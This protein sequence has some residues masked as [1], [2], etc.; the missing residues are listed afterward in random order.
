MTNSIPK[1]QHTVSE[2]LIKSEHTFQIHIVIIMYNTYLTTHI[3]HLYFLK[4]LGD[5][6]HDNF[7]NLTNY[8]RVLF[9]LL[10]SLN[11]DPYKREDKQ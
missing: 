7:Y 5:S 10:V 1:I 4:N 9:Y 3:C 2:L 6:I 8:T 11:T